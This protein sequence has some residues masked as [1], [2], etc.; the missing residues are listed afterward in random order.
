MVVLAPVPAEMQSSRPD[1]LTAWQ[2]W[3]KGVQDTDFP[4][5]WKL[6]RRWKSNPLDE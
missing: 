6:R 4:E 5:V 2:E 3:P 1:I